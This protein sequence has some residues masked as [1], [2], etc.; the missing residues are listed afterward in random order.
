[1]GQIKQS[2]KT[3]WGRCSLTGFGKAGSY[4]NSA[5][6]T[7]QPVRHYYSLPLLF[8]ELPIVVSILADAIHDG[9]GAREYA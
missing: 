4:N 3:L 2:A 9:K 1:M 5:S 7:F 6:E 8:H